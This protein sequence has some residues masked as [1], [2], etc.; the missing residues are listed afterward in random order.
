MEISD[1]VAIITGGASGLGEA[2]VQMFIKR[3]AKVAI[4]DLD[5][6]R[7]QRIASD[8]GDSCGD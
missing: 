5:E 7:G 3:N 1:R 6:E 8:L 2:T 4:L